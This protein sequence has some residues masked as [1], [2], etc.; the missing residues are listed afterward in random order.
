MDAYVVDLGIL[1]ENLRICRECMAGTPIW[2]AVK[3]DG[4]G[5]G[6]E[7]YARVLLAEG[8]DRFVVS[9][10]GEALWLRALGFA[11]DV[12][13][14]QTVSDRRMLKEL[15]EK[16]ILLTVGSLR[17]YGV[18]GMAAW[19]WGLKARAHIYIDSGMGWEGFGPE[20]RLRLL[21]LCQRESPIR[22]E[23]LYT[24]FPAAWGPAKDTVR[25]FGVFRKLASELKAAGWQGQCHCAASGAALRFPEMRLDGVRL[26]SA[27]LGRVPG[28][29]GQALGLRPVGYI[30]AGIA[31]IHEIGPGQ[32]L[33]YAGSFTAKRKTRV[34]VVEVGYYHGYDTERCR[35]ISGWKDCLRAMLSPLRSFLR[36]EQRRALVAGQPAEVL[37]QVSMHHTLLDVTDC[38]CRAGDRAILPC[39]PLM[40][41]HLPRRFL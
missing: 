15:M 29:V 41:R 10:P 34:A 30:D 21:R 38:P 16:D 2:A 28:T 18:L 5:L 20:D 36:G 27:L 35:G 22:L 1:R 11:G 14:L 37:G 8:F 40:V 7:D 9:E 23:G 39:N 24:H 12:L 17:S 26:G 13:L 4:Y 3:G 19:Q 32:R 31:A 25:R 33:G 6:L